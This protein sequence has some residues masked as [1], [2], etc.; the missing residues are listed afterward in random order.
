MKPEG[1]P[2]KRPRSGAEAAEVVASAPGRAGILGNPT[3]GYGGTVI[4]C[5]IPQR[6]TVTLRAADRLRATVHLSPPAGSASADGPREKSLVLAAPQDLQLRGDEF[7]VVRA[8]ARFLGRHRLTAE[9]DIRTEVPVQCGLAGSTAILSSLL[10]GALRLLGLEP[11]PRHPQYRYLLAEMVRSVELHFLKVQCG[12]QDQYMT[13][14]GG[15]N[16]M[17]FRGKEHYRTLQQELFATVEPLGDLVGK[18]PVVVVSTGLRRVSGH[19]LKP[20][21]ERWLEGDPVVRRGYRRIAE[22]ARRGKR[23]LLSRDWRTLAGLMNQNHSIQQQVGASGEAMD[24]AIEV[25]RGAGAWGAKLAGAG[26]GGSIILLHPE[27]GD[28]SAQALPTHPVVGAVV[29]RYPGARLIVPTP[30]PGVTC[31]A[32]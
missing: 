26:G 17:E 23:A 8:V 21:R 9:V 29:A 15:L 32:R 22:L 13:V 18:L 16:C 10:A 1:P 5:S 12:Y 30:Q 25:A 4:S 11:H 24:E 27:F 14:F 3:D 31:Q 28:S 2:R 6:A 20:V 19:I 7:D